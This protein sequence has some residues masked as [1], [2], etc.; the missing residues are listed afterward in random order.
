MSRKGATKQIRI[1]GLFIIIGLIIEAFTLGWSSPITFLVFLTVGGFFF[2]VGLGYA[3]TLLLIPR[4][5][6]PEEGPKKP[7]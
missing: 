4:Y 7:S 1:A 2:F 3:L 5:L 6:N